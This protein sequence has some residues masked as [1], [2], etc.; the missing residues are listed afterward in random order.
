MIGLALL[1]VVAVICAGGVVTAL[2]IGRIEAAHPPAGRFVE[3]DG[4]RLH[5]LELD[6]ADADVDAAADTADPRWPVVLV[7]GASGN[8]GDLRLALGDRLAQTRRVILV[9]RPGHGWSDR[10][11]G[12]EDASPAR[13]AALI[14]QALER[15]GIE[16]FVL[17]GHSLGGAV[18]TAFALAYPDRLAGLVLLAPVTHPWRGGLAWYNALLTTPLA[19]RVFAHALALPAGELLLEDSA[20]EVFAPQPMPPDYLRRAGIRLL[21]RPAEFIANAQ[22]VAVLKRF[23]TAQVPRYRDIAVPTVVLTGDADVTVSPHLHARAI[24]AALPDA[25]LVILPGIGH[26][27]QHVATNEVI[28]AIDLVS[29]AATLPRAPEKGV[30]FNYCSLIDASA[31]VISRKP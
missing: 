13:Q 28:A 15:M 16:R 5:V 12:A 4:G 27:P 2:T 20:Q 14:A 17:L 19:G 22:D 18:A 9:D 26:M 11:G 1:A 24:A 23:V 29:A 21:L 31:L 25:R 10:P 7:H 30:A 6:Q 3:V 8:L